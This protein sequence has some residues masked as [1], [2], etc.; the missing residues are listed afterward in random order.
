MIAYRWGVPAD[1][2]RRE[3][4]R[5]DVAGLD[6]GRGDWKSG[7]SMYIGSYQSISTHW[8]EDY[9]AFKPNYRRDRL[10]RDR[11]ARARTE[12]KQK[13]KEERAAQRKAE[14]A[15]SEASSE[16]QQD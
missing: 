16:E 10:E 5:Y 2:P 15:T 6:R 11:A 13:K 9:M 7:T 8:H 3:N 14:R 4:V 1:S 12:E